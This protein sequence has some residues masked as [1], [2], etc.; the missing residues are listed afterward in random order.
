MVL[1]W[2]PAWVPLAVGST[3]TPQTLTPAAEAHRNSVLGP[4][5]I[6]GGGAVWAPCLPTTWTEQPLPW[7]LVPPRKKGTGVGGKRSKAPESQLV[8][9]PTY[10][11]GPAGVLPLARPSR[12]GPRCVAPP[13][14]LGRLLSPPLQA[15]QA[16][17]GVRGCKEPLSRGGQRQAGLRKAEV[18]LSCCARTGPWCHPWC[19]HWGCGVTQ[20]GTGL[21][22]CS[23]PCSA[24]AVVSL[25]P[26]G[27]CS[28]P[29]T[30]VQC[31]EL[32]RGRPC[33]LQTASHACP[34][35]PAGSRSPDSG[36]AMRSTQQPGLF[37]WVDPARP[38]GSVGLRCS[39]SGR[40]VHVSQYHPGAPLIV[41]HA[42][43]NHGLCG[44]DSQLPTS[45]PSSRRSDLVLLWRL[46]P[47][48]LGHRMSRQD[49]CQ[50]GH[51]PRLGSSCAGVAI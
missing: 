35:G 4:L 33:F 50:V 31:E 51:P 11:L 9:G 24:G 18:E 3:V 46:F 41:P 32:E 10:L 13:L 29:R 49:D 2:P 39:P 40:A 44:S 12:N 26:S 42:C 20:R 34:L 36:E 45:L 14:A 6:R 1:A 37:R 25:M 47:E 38:S 5:A 27:V 8:C 16:P 19:R 28:G 15:M 22:L 48:A 23:A 17:L 7:A 43:I 30:W 21:G